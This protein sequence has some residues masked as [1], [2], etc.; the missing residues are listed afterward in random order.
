MSMKKATLAQRLKTLRSRR[1]KLRA[2]DVAA[3]VGISRAYLSAIENGHDLPGRDVLA[4]LAE[5]YE[6]SSEFLLYGRDAKQ[7]GELVEDPDELALLDFWR[8]LHSEYRPV[9]L[10]M[11]AAAA[12][13]VANDAAA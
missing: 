11:L 5:Y 3:T 12:G 7:Q 6:V 4:R 8:S 10:K 1:P 13:S 9:V 2:D